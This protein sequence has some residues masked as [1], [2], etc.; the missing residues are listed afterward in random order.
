MPKSHLFKSVA[1]GAALF[2]TAIS[3]A[4]SEAPALSPNSIA[5]PSDYQNWQILGVSHRSDKNSLR[6]ILANPVAAKAA[7]EGRN[8]PWPDGSMI[9]KLA[10]KDS[11]HPQFAAATV[12][13][14]LSHVEI[15]TRDSKKY[16]NTN[17]WGY[18]RWLG[19]AQKPY[20][21]NA[22]F[23]KECAACHLQAK[24]TGHVFTRK[25][26]LPESR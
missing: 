3:S 18:A 5:L 4:R 11:V 26:P 1:F 23:A 22:D 10:W 2:L 24:D 17:G 8:N 20:G 13:G 21:E 19:M 16:A 15:M 12:P 25:A 14:D 7:A 9:A 6:I